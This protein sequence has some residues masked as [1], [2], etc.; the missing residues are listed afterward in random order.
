MKVF[1]NIHEAYLSVLSDVYHNYQ[2][3]SSPRGQACR[4]ITDYTFR[5]TNPSCESII[6]KDS[7]R[8]KVIQSYMEKEIEL[9]NSCTNRVEDFAKASTFWN[10]L[11][12]PDGTINSAYGYL[13]WRRPSHG[14]PDYETV[15]AK[16]TDLVPKPK[17]MPVYRTPWDWAK[18]S[19]IKD[20]DTRQAIVRFSLPDHQW[21]GNKDQICTMHGNFLIRENK[22]HLSIVMRSNDLTLGLIYDLPWFMSLIDRM[23]SELKKTYPELEKG[24]YTHTVHSMHV[25]ERNK[26]MILKMLGEK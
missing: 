4:E 25:Y 24:T 8:N 10:K 23:V 26:E 2:Y 12:N 7:E 15:S 5:V 9:Y 11:A 3:K 14:N 18:E 1:D 16:P 13:I 21:M 19:L 17:P 20:K 6:T 22:L